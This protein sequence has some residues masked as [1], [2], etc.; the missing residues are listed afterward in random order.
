MTVGCQNDS[1]I[2][3]DHS[4]RPNSAGKLINLSSLLHRWLLLLLR[5][6]FLPND[7]RRA[8]TTAN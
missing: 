4:C 2:I 7:N 1:L 6:E 5:V 3:V 8:Y